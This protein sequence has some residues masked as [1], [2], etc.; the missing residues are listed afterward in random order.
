MRNAIIGAVTALVI[1]VGGSVGAYTA[2]EHHLT[3][4]VRAFL[5]AANDPH[6]T[7]AEAEAYIAQARPLLKTKKDR[8]VAEEFEEGVSLLES[9]EEESQ[10]EYQAT[11]SE[12][13][14]LSS[15]SEDSSQ[16]DGQFHYYVHLEQ[17]YKEAG[18]AIPTEVKAQFDEAY[19]AIQP[20]EDQK[21]ADR[22]AAEKRQQADFRNGERLVNNAR[23]ELGL[24]PL[25]N[26]E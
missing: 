2:Y 26:D 7:R 13:S 23:R 21:K 8:K 14:E 25:K 4:Q 16:C 9:S 11:L 17:K 6:A 15:D 19:K 20:C 10:Q 12:I 22:L 3:S 5:I 18:L 1:I 24:Q